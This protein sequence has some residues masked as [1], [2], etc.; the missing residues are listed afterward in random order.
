LGIIILNI[1]W[2]RNIPTFR[3]AGKT[4]ADR[5]GTREKLYKEGFDVEDLCDANNDIYSVIGHIVGIP[6]EDARR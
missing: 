5:K 3:V 1:I 4:G 6:W 2:P